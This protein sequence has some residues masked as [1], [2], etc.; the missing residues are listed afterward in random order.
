MSPWKTCEGDRNRERSVRNKEKRL[1]SDR[2]K[3]RGK[4][5]KK[6]LFSPFCA[7]GSRGASYFPARGLHLCWGGPPPGGTLWKDQSVGLNFSHGRR[8]EKRR[9]RRRR[10]ILGTKESNHGN[11]GTSYFHEHF[12]IMPHK[13][14]RRKENCFHLCD[15]VVGRPH[16]AK[17][18]SKQPL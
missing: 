2:D 11:L 9:K 7:R 10:G 17:Q 5:R 16:Q 8:R 1:G 4:L 12:P 13:S 6:K 3:K 15:I 18:A 14:A